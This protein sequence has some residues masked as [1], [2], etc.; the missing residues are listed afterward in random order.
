MVKNVIQKEAKVMA[1]GEE[2]RPRLM[3]STKR[4]S[5]KKKVE[6]ISLGLIGLLLIV[7][8]MMLRG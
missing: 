3:R 7:M 2:N 4:C 5:S 1:K 6:N 8:G